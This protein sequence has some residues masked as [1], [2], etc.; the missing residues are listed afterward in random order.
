MSSLFSKQRESAALLPGNRFFVRLV[1]LE[2]EN[3]ASQVSLA[4]ETVSPFPSEQMLMGY[5]T[6]TD[7]KWALAYAAHRRR[8]TPEESFAW[9]DDCQVIPEF[10]A[11]LGQRPE[12]GGILIHEGADLLTALAWNESQPLPKCVLVVDKKDSSTELLTQEILERTGLPSGTPVV[13]TSG[14]FSSE[15]NDSQLVL[16][17]N[18]G[19]PFQLSS[20]QLDNADIRDADFLSTR[21]KKERVNKLLWNTARIAVGVIIVS[22]VFEISAFLIN[23]RSNN[24]RLINES[25]QAGVQEIESA[26]AISARITDMNTKAPLP[27]EMLAIA[28]DHRPATVDFQRV[29]CKNNT[30]LEIE[31]RTTN[32]SDVYTFEKSLKETAEVSFVATKDM[33]ARD[34]FTTFSVT[35]TFKPET[36]RKG[37]K[38]K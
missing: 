37:V 1:E 29:S 38:N 30:Q 11:L 7:N 36:L 10:L 6:S 21:R 31:A 20:D 23:W 35:I 25:R 3:I 12:K 4:I 34:N 8:F 9:P 15:R 32:A 27:L 28:N 14:E 33:R 17:C 26:Q 16:N 2:P 22:F 5:I 13:T 19:K 18:S 24:L